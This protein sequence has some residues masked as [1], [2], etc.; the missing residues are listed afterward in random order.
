MRLKE[1]VKDGTDVLTLSGEI[2]LPYAPVLR[3]LLQ[4]KVKALCPAL[5]LDLSAVRFIDSS[6]LAAIIE[7]FRDT[8]EHEGVLCLCGLNDTLQTIF[9]IVQLK[10]VIPIFG[11]VAEATTAL[12]QGVVHSPRAA[13]FGRTAA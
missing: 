6:G 13:L 3:A 2:D 5:I 12:Q 1:S 9:E 4:G 7:Y 10:S 8:S 11:S